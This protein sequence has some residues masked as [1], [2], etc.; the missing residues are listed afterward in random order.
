MVDN[1]NSDDNAVK[2]SGD[3][4]PGD[5]SSLKARLGLNVEK[6]KAK[7]KSEQAA[8]KPAAPSPPTLLDAPPAAPPQGQ[9]TAPMAGQPFPPGPSYMPGDQEVT[10]SHMIIDAMQRKW[11]IRLYFFSIVPALMLGGLGYLLGKRGQTS[12]IIDKTMADSLTVEKVIARADSRI[13]GLHKEFVESQER[14]KLKGKLLQKTTRRMVAGKPKIVV[15][16]RRFAEADWELLDKLKNVALPADLDKILDVSANRFGKMTAHQVMSFYLDAKQFF[17]ELTRFAWYAKR[18]KAA[19]KKIRGGRIN[20][21]AVVVSNET[22]KPL[23]RGEIVIFLRR[24]RVNATPE[25]NKRKKG[26]PAFLLEVAKL[27]N[28]DQGMTLNPEEVIVLGH[29]ELFKQRHALIDEYNRLF[30]QVIF[31]A[32]DIKKYSE[33]VITSLKEIAQGG[34]KRKRGL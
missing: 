2:K 21:Y 32:N 29:S 27:Q 8:P 20:R 12:N 17:R 1:K 26:A 5:L 15:V 4:A 14:M 33:M 13:K 3:N 31:K 18:N 6:P 22:G 28:P 30:R 9:M 16:G 23:R 25:K 10:S 11:R 7:P 19:L 34:R 24:K